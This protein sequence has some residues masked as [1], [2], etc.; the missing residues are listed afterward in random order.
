MI[1][2]LAAIALTPAQQT[3]KTLTIDDYTVGAY[4]KTLYFGQSDLH[5]VTGLDKR[6]CL[7]GDRQTYVD[8]TANPNQT[9]LSFSLGGHSQAFTSPM[10]VDWQYTAAYGYYT[11]G[12]VDLSGVD[13]FIA[14]A[15]K[16]PDLVSVLVN[17]VH[18]VTG[19]TGNW[20]LRGGG[21]YFRKTDFS[22][23]SIVDWK[24]I[25]SIEFRQNFPNLPNPLNYSVTRFYVSLAPTST[26]APN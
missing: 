3:V 23:F 8:I 9:T 24:H 11:S 26:S 25:K 14:D 16:V 18:G 13:K 2:A 21:Y 19:S 5:V 15:N 12:T 22:Q 4:T 10:Q 1:L 20:L 7:F 17:D 6:H